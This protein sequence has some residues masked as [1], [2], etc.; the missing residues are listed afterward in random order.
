MFVGKIIG[1][2]LGLSS[3]GLFG[4]LIGIAVGHFF[5]RGFGRALGFDYGADR[6]RIQQLFFETSFSIMGHLAKDDGRISQEEISQAEGLM[7]QLGLAVEQRQQAIALFKLGAEQDFQLEPTIGRFINEG[8]RQQNLPIL[9]F[10][11]LFS[12]AMADGEIH[13]AEKEILGR[14]AAYLGINARQFDQLLSMLMAQQNF[15]GGHYQQQGQYAR[16]DELKNAYEALGVNQSNSDKEIKRPYR[17]LMEPAS[18]R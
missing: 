16:E 13:P 15:R 5:D 1:G 10:E 8:G 18:P 4:G 12:M 6:E 17:K 11:F 9:L 7:T 14:T 3:G 2:L